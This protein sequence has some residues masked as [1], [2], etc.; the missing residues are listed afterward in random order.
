[1]KEHRGCKNCAH[2]EPDDCLAGEHIDSDSSWLFMARHL[3]EFP[4]WECPRR[5]TTTAGAVQDVK[6]AF[7][8]LIS[9]IWEAWTR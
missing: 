7:K 2:Y 8:D 5:Y 9:T 6:D 4:D 1:M 3:A